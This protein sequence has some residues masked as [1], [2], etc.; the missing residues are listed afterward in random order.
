MGLKKILTLFW[1][2]VDNLVHFDSLNLHYKATRKNKRNDTS[3]LNGVLKIGLVSIL[4]VF[5]QVKVK[6]HIPS[7]LLKSPYKT[8]N[9]GQEVNLMDPM[10]SI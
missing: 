4:S 1:S 6:L 10:Y 3:G 8:P 7:H 2:S 5:D 9:D